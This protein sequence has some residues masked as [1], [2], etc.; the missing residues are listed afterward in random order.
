VPG[1][2]SKSS[3]LI[4]WVRVAYLKK[5]AARDAR[6]TKLLYQKY[7]ERDMPTL[8]AC[9]QCTLENTYVDGSLW[10]CADCGFEWSA[11]ADLAEVTDSVIKDA[12]GNVLQ[13]GDSV[14]V[15]K[16][17]KV[18]SS[19]I[20]LKLGTK[21]KNIRLKSGD[22]DVE[23]KVDGVGMMLKSIFLKKA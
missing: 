8:P 15:V 4:P 5:P 23:C 2:Q 19:S 14:L 13:D 12:F 6:S 9:P 22:H 21:I 17:L 16:E 1:A 20:T 3:A 11:A 10:I 7:C 18:K